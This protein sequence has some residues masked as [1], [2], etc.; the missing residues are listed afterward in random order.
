MVKK[1]I[2]RKGVVVP[3]NLHSKMYMTSSLERK[4]RLTPYIFDDLGSIDPGSRIDL[5]D[6]KL[7]NDERPYRN[8]DLI[9]F[10]ENNLIEN[11]TDEE[12]RLEPQLEDVLKGYMLY[13]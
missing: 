4:I 7:I 11:N 12:Q 9:G 1:L 13:V 2:K 10:S 3:N 8:L 6:P 5:A